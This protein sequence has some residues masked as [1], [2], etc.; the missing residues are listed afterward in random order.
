MQIHCVR[1]KS[2]QCTT[3]MPNLN[4]AQ[5]NYV[6][7]ILNMSVKKKP[8]F[9]SKI[10]FDKRVINFQVS[11]TKYLCFEY[12]VTFRCLRMTENTVDLGISVSHA[13]YRTIWWVPSYVLGL[14]VQL[15][16]TTNILICSDCKPPP[17]TTLS[18]DGAI[19]VNFSKQLLEAWQRPQ[20][21]SNS[22]MNC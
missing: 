7:L 6:Q 17:T 4:G 19:H 20:L 11:I 14:T 10:L 8:K 21:V 1:D 9:C 2:R 3:E 12:S 18:I 13:I 15:L 5:Q 16:N 22:T